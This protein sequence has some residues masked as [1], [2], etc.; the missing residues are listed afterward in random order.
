[1][2]PCNVLI[3]NG[4]CKG[5]G[6]LKK[7]DVRQLVSNVSLSST[8]LKI[9][10]ELDHFMAGLDGAGVLHVISEISSSSSA[11]VCGLGR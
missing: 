2:E 5:L 7:D 8:I 4:C 11:N 10:T 6:Q 9:K 3:D 1:M